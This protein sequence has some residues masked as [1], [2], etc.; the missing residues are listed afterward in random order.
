MAHWHCWRTDNARVQFPFNAGL[1]IYIVQAV[2]KN[3]A[4]LTV[5]FNLVQ[6]AA[7]VANELNLWRHVSIGTRAPS[8]P[9]PTPAELL[10]D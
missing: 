8:V 9:F 10:I 1:Y 7:L 4:L 2:N 6:T 3:L 5:L